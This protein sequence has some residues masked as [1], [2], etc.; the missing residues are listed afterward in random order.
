M[1]GLEIV[2]DKTT[3]QPFDGKIS[4]GERIVE[5]AMAK[6]LI[7]RPTGPTVVI[8][9]PFIMTAAEQEWMFDTIEEVLDEVQAGLPR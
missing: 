3:K 6:G 9:P 5:R 2:A 4:A 1:G 7:I 8:S